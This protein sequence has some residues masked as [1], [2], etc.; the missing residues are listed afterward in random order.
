M[1]MKERE[2]LILK[3]ELLKDQLWQQIGIKNMRT[4]KPPHSSR[5]STHSTRSFRLINKSTKRNNYKVN[6]TRI[7]TTKIL[8][9]HK[10]KHE[11]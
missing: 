10:P 11:F 4:F 7:N 5:I 1:T 9:K 6:S 8:I 3:L 2:M